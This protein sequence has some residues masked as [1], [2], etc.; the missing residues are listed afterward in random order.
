MDGGLKIWSRRRWE[1]EKGS[2]RVSR[3]RG[4]AGM[5]QWPHLHCFDPLTLPSLQVDHLRRC[6]DKLSRFLRAH[7]RSVQ[8]DPSN[9]ST[10]AS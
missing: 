6:D 7:T 5:T 4:R 3:D 1:R 9:L 2:I 8:Q 10:T